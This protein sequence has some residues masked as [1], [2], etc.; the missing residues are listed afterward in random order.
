M[1]EGNQSLAFDLQKGPNKLQVM[2]FFARCQFLPSYN[3]QNFEEMFLTGFF[4]KH[5]AIFNPFNTNP[6][7]RYIAYK[8]AKEGNPVHNLIKKAEDVKRAERL[9][10]AS[11]NSLQPSPTKAKRHLTTVPHV[12]GR[13][14]LRWGGVFGP[15]KMR[16]KTK[17]NRPTNFWT[18]GS[19][20]HPCKYNVLCSHVIGAHEASKL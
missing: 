3:L 13:T 16:S 8:D 14:W 12:Q 2:G 10:M 15:K 5:L 18:F 11:V 19:R 1:L 17:K 9:W 7:F 6:T 4:T 20:T